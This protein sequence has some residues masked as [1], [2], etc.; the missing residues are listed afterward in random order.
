MLLL[1]TALCGGLLTVRWVIPRSFA[2][3]ELRG[4]E[5]E[6]LPSI[7]VDGS[8]LQC[9]R[10][11]P[12]AFDAGLFVLWL[13]LDSTR[14]SVEA[15]QELLAPNERRPIVH[16]S[17]DALVV[18]KPGETP[19]PLAWEGLV[20]R[21]GHL[22]VSG[23]TIIDWLGVQLRHRGLDAWILG[24][25]AVLLAQILALF[26]LVILHRL[27]FSRRA[28]AS[29]PGLGRAGALASLPPTVVTM[30][31]G[32][33]GLSQGGMIGVYLLAFGLTFLLM[34]NSLV[35]GAVVPGAVVPR[36]VAIAADGSPL[37]DGDLPMGPLGG[38]D[39][40]DL[41]AMKQRGLLS[42]ED[43]ALAEDLLSG[44]SEPSSD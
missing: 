1:V 33:A 7:I 25:G 31:L 4:T 12:E 6:Q 19:R 27:V 2:L 21:E 13:E 17:A 22:M 24:T 20:R 39:R 29:P 15:T 28:G 44:K 10:R 5:I 32:S 36:A 35:R 34:A 23:V 3:E 11:G 38:L 16:I 30:I 26:I 40:A 42:D 9:P 14:P 43:Y 37:R 18:Y 41:E 8:G